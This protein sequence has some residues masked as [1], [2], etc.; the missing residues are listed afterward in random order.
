MKSKI[1]YML[2]CLLMIFSFI[3][4]IFAEELA[5]TMTANADNTEVVAGG[6]ATITVSLKSDSAIANCLFTIE[7]DST[8]ELVSKSG[9]NNW[10]FDSYEGSGKDLISNSSLDNVAYTE[11][12]NIFNL[13][14][15]VN[16]DGKVNIKNIKCVSTMAE[17]TDEEGNN[18]EIEGS[19]QDITVSF[20]VK[21]TGEDTTLSNL[22]VTGGKLLS[23]FSSNRF[24]YQIELDSPN[25]SLDMTT[26]NTEF[27]D[28]IVVTDT[29]GNKLDPKNITFSNDG[30]QGYMYIKIVVNGN[31]SQSYQ[32]AAHYGQELD[33][34]LS[35]L[36]INGESVV[37]KTGQTDYTFNVGKDITE[38]N[39]IAELTDSENFQF[40]EGN[41]PGIFKLS[42]GTTSIAL[43]IV[44]KNS[45]IGASSKTYIIEI[46]KEGGTN[47]GDSS[48]NDG[49]NV[50]TNP[51]TGEISVFIMSFILISSL[52]GSVILYIKTLKSYR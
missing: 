30:G 27:Q 24:S 50:T 28:K 37:L 32:L 44:P 12:K 41:E 49:G 43:M 8:L 25:F 21:D 46:V 18:T 26:S 35:S 1:F 14:Y 36:K 40:R 45:Q 15:K 11:G 19:F 52:V 22:A 10:N 31:D 29:N 33:N 3:K 47:A 42:G 4:I 39:V 48:Y 5:F 13:K 17:G 23:E 7:T 34:S 16:G 2:L 9:L 51:G 6:E 20:T 38:V